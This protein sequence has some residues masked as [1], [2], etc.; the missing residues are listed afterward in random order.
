MD[1]VRLW[2]HE[3]IRV[4][5]DKMMSKTD[6]E[7][8][9][10]LVTD[11][12][13]KQ[14]ENLDANTV[15]RQPLIYSHFADGIGDDKYGPIDNY[16]QLRKLLNEALINYNDIVGALDLVLFEDAMSHICRYVKIFFFIF[17]FKVITKFF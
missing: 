2:Y 10:K 9:T 12:A 5:G 3:S 4:Y 14:I 15:F 17:G 8:L 6:N 13:K 11:I 7:I 1:F 16:G